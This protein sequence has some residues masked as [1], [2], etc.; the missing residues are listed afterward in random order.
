M[1]HYADID[2]MSLFSS[3]KVFFSN[4]CF[5]SYH[6]ATS[7]ILVLNHEFNLFIEGINDEEISDLA[8]ILC[9]YR[10]IDQ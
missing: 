7:A 10:S 9:D 5:Q 2:R 4:L 8:L 3:L 6:H 1:C